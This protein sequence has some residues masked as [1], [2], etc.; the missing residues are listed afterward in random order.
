MDMNPDLS[1]KDDRT[2]NEISED[3]LRLALERLGANNRKRPGHV[4]HTK[5]SPEPRRRRFVQEG[6]VVVEHHQVSRTTQRAAPAT[7]DD[8]SD[9]INRLRNLVK[10]EQRRAED[11]QRELSD[12]QVQLRTLETHLVHEK[13]HVKELKTRCADIEQALLD[14]QVM[15]ERLREQAPAPKMAVERVAPSGAEGV[16]KTRG[17]GRPPKVRPPVD[18]SNEPE[19]VQ[20]W[21]D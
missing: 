20:W 15:V 4:T 16:K 2:E 10:L 8:Q 17:P 6:Q 3:S 5:S 7:S 14:S 21:K 18:P 12:A 11:A 1:S 13:L 19:P 9:E